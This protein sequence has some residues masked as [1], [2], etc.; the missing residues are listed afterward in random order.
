MDLSR[1]VVVAG[2]AGI[3]GRFDVKAIA[4]DRSLA[5]GQEQAGGSFGYGVRQER[6][7]CRAMWSRLDQTNHALA[8]LA[9]LAKHVRQQELHH[10]ETLES[11]L[12]RNRHLK[13]GGGGKARNKI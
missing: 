7:G 8:W 10:R 5:P 13:R 9:F 12:R 1:G 6:D 11:N 3:F 2:G 4:N